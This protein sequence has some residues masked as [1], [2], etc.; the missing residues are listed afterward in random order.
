MKGRELEGWSI[1]RNPEESGVVS[2]DG[3][4]SCQVTV[5]GRYTT[6]TEQ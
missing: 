6:Y 5:R 1:D 2:Y 4:T 3:C